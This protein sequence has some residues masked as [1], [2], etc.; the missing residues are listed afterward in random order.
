MFLDLFQKY[1]SI[2]GKAGF[3]LYLVGGAVRDHM[4]GKQSKDLDFATNAKPE[5]MKEILPNADF[6]FAKYG[7]VSMK[8]D[9][10]SL[11]FTTFRKEGGYKDSR[12]PSSIIFV[13]D[14]RIDSD[15]RDFTI[16]ALYLDCQ[17][18]IHDYHGGLRDL[19]EKLIR[20]IGDPE[21]RIKEDPLR[22]LRAERFASSL[23]FEIEEESLKA[24]NELRPLLEKINP[25]KI[26]M[27]QKKIKA[28]VK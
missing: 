16:N 18:D 23:G 28:G 9:G 24:I 4:L 17:G 8:E 26:K 20:F 10:Y 6:T 7:A 12:H 27:E 5:Q 13:D 15:R 3:C 22:I 2:F 14:P 1:A 19:A 25:E 11:T 21:T